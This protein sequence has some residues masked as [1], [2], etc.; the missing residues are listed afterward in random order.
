M[1]GRHG[2]SM[3]DALPSRELAAQIPRTFDGLHLLSFQGQS[4]PRFSKNS[5]LLRGP[6]CTFSGKCPDRPQRG[7]PPRS[8]RI[9]RSSLLA[10]EP[11]QSG[12]ARDKLPC[13]RQRRPS[14]PHSA[15]PTWEP[16]RAAVLPPP[17][18][19]TFRRN[20]CGALVRCR[21]IISTPPRPPLAN[22]VGQAP[23]HTTHTCRIRF[24]A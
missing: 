14:S 17:A 8:L 22:L 6:P 11:R 5:Q 18:Q 2:L 10:I 24:L 1:R 7:S 20:L 9:G 13:Q 23:P 3:C 15:R 21:Q 16:S 12:V 19:Q 4:M